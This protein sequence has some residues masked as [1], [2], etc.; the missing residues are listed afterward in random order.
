M[1]NFLVVALALALSACIKIVDVPFATDPRIMRGEW[2]GQMDAACTSD[3]TNAQVN[4]D[5]SRLVSRGTPAAIWDFAT[6]TK[7]ALLEQNANEFIS[8]VC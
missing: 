5:N 6:G 2:T 8:Q 3:V 7:T 4:T 1:R